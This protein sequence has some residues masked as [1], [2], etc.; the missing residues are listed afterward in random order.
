MCI[1]SQKQKER[2]NNWVLAG[3]MYVPTIQNKET[4]LRLG[5]Y[6]QSIIFGC[7]TFSFSIYILFS[8]FFAKEEKKLWR[9]QTN[10]L[11]LLLLLFLLLLLL[12][13]CVQKMFLFLVYYPQ[14]WSGVLTVNSRHRYICV[15]R[16]QRITI[17]HNYSDLFLLATRLLKP[18]YNAP[19][20]EGKKEEKKMNTKCRK[21]ILTSSPSEKNDSKEK[22]DSRSRRRSSKRDIPY[23]KRACM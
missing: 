23:S 5:T 11:L 1:L 2:K 21:K 18:S 12:L 20:K 13:F 14:I 3:Y 4:F 7:E 22:R 19:K 10:V 16:T 6:K 9:K 17:G 8:S 15:P